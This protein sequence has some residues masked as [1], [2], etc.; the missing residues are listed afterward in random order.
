LVAAALTMPP[1]GWWFPANARR[2]GE[3]IHGKSASDIIGDVMRRSGARGTPHSLRHWHG[4]TLLEDGADLRTVQELLRHKS[5][6]TTQIYTKVP[7]E[8]RHAAVVRLDPF[9]QLKPAA[10]DGRTVLQQLQVSTAPMVVVR[11]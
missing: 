7:D 3:H 2:P 11:V 1:R 5:L 6:S 4:T 8:R 10:G 9:R